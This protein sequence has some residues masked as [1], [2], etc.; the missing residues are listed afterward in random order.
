MFGIITGRQKGPITRSNFVPTSN[1][2]MFEFDKIKKYA[3]QLSYVRAKYKK[4]GKK[5]IGRIRGISE[6]EKR[7]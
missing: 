5:L 7:E 4:S 3:I 6:L 1:R 2:Y